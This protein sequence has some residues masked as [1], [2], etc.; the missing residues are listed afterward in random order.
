MLVIHHKD[1]RRFNRCQDSY[2]IPSVPSTVKD[3]VQ[4]TGLINRPFTKR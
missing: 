2:L 1:A 3:P 4:K